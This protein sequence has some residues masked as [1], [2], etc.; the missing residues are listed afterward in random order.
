MCLEHPQQGNL[1]PAATAGSSRELNETCLPVDARLWWWPA[2]SLR[3]R[4]G[5]Q[6]RI[7][8]TCSALLFL[9]NPTFCSLC[10]SETLLGISH[11]SPAPHQ[12]SHVPLRGPI[13]WVAGVPVHRLEVGAPQYCPGVL[14][15][16]CILSLSD[17][18]R[19][20]E[21]NVLCGDLGT[22]ASRTSF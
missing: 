15:I 8:T 17:Q 5:G 13:F 20:T 10:P 19:G 18:M 14:S 4:C 11:C 2:H 1:S 9:K 16:R 12:A 21:R 6:S 22:A 7:S 3:L